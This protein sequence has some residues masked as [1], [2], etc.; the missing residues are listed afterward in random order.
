MRNCIRAACALVS[1]A[2][3]GG[4]A[5]A[6]CSMCRTALA[7]HGHNAGDAFN[8]AILI[9]LLPAIGLFGTVFGLVFRYADSTKDTPED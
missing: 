3:A 7:A 1:M 4:P 8:R 6:Q 5:A 2:A 9:L